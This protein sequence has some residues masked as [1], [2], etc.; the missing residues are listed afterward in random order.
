MLPNKSSYRSYFGDCKKFIK[1]KY[2][3]ENVGVS[4]T[5]FSKFMQSD[6]FDYYISINKLEEIRAELVLVLDSLI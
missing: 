3:L 1:F 4:Q 5:T 2:I 6:V